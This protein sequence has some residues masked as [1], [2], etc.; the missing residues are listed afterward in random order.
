MNPDHKALL[1]SIQAG[2]GSG[3]RHPSPG[4]SYAAGGH[5]YYSV[6]TPERRRIVRSWLATHKAMPPS[7]VLALVDSLFA[8]DSYEEKTIA[9]I[10]LQCHL[11]ARQLV[12]PVDV[13]RWLSHLAGWAEI[14]SLC[15]SVFTAEQLLAG[16]PGWEDLLSKLSRSPD[17][18]KR[19][20]SL[21]LLT[22]PIRDSPDNRLSDRAFATINALKSERAILITKAVSWLLRSM[23]GHHRDEVIACLAAN[24]ATLP[25]IAVRETRFKIETGTKSGHSRLGKGSA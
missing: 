25:A 7:E 8:G 15:Q 2:A 18:G 17:V 11:P 10:L 19:R 21:V 5:R 20:A 12:I 9:A 1:L 22:G 6:S 24:E 23:V 14:D 13:D 4:D 3:P 16:W